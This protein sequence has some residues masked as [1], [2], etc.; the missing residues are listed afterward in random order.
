MEYIGYLCGSFSLHEGRVKTAA[1]LPSRWRE[2]RLSETELHEYGQYYLPDF[3]RFCL[4]PDAGE[5][6]AMQRFTTDCGCTFKL[7]RMV[8]VKPP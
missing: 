4:N 3:V 6:V 1:R 7:K 8:S 2:L 5:D